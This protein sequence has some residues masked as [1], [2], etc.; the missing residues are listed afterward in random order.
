MDGHRFA[1]ANYRIPLTGRLTVTPGLTWGFVCSV[2]GQ[3]AY[4][5]R[6]FE[7]GRSASV[8]SGRETRDPHLVKP[9]REP[10]VDAPSRVDAAID[11]SSITGLFPRRKSSTVEMSI[12]SSEVHAEPAPAIVGPSEELTVCSRG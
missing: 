6:D 12:E 2:E 4:R 9:P 1:P 10:A 7:R 11:E 3:A 5:P 8:E